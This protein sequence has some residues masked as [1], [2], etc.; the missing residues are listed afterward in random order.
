[1][2]VE[3]KL[4]LFEATALVFV[5]PERYK[6]GTLTHGK[7]IYGDVINRNGKPFVWQV[8][9][10][11]AVPCCEGVADCTVPYGSGTRD[12]NCPVENLN[13]GEQYYHEYTYRGMWD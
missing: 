4:E 8:C 7:Y 5:N 9:N 1:M 12:G 2:L 11:D 13:C 6:V 10:Y 3:N